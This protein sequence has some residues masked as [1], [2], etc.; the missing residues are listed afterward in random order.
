MVF[1]FF[2][3]LISI[4][5]LVKVC[6]L[7][8]LDTL[9]LHCISDLQVFCSVWEL[10]VWRGGTE[11]RIG[12]FTLKTTS[13]FQRQKGWLRILLLLFHA[14]PWERPD[15]GT[16]ET[17]RLPEQPSP[18]GDRRQ[19]LR[20]R[21][22]EVPTQIPRWR[23]ADP[24]RLQSVAQTPCGQ[25]KTA[26]PAGCLPYPTPSQVHITCIDQS[27]TVPPAGP[28][29]GLWSHRNRNPKSASTACWLYRLSQLP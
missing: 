27:R 22:Q 14:S 24:G 3:G 29:P 16:E 17:G 18:R 20:R 9:L 25:G 2:E 4:Y 5:C 19:H 7:R 6:F 11:F 1:F 13:C 15:Q 12:S 23:R 26:L 10:A 8:P 28:E 21:R